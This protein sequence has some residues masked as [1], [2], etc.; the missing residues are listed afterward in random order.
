MRVG[1]VDAAGKAGWV[2]VVLEDGHFD[3]AHVAR[4]LADL[5]GDLGPADAIG[6]DIPIGGTA[7]GFRQAD[8]LARP[9][10]GARRSSV[11]AAPP[12]D[13]WTAESYEAANEL[14]SSSGRPKLSRQSWAL[15]PKIREADRVSRSDDRVVEV[16]PEVSF[17]AMA[18]VDLPSKKTWDGMIRRRGL[19]TDNGIEVPGRLGP[20]GNVAV[21]DVLDAAAV[22]WSAGRIARGVATSLPDPPEAGVDGREVAIWF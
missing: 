11:F 16:H 19:L 3:R 22:A 1:G 8:R 17:R 4:H 7:A 9:L 5:V 12:P 21:D 10:V 6:V 15:V 2:A 13:I 18:G 20:A 14:L